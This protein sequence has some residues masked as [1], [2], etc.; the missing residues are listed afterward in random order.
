MYL[1]F[2][3][4]VLLFY[5]KTFWKQAST[6]LLEYTMRIRLPKYYFMILMCFLDL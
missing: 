6:L 4:L 1:G 3:V 5:K 2:E